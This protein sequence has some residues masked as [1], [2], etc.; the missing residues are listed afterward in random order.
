[1]SDL[2][3]AVLLDLDG[4]C[5]DSEPIWEHVERTYV[6]AHGA[7]LTAEHRRRV[8]GA[9]MWLTTQVIGEATGVPQDPAVLEPLLVAGVAARY[10][11][12]GVPW[13]PGVARLIRWMHD[14]GVPVALVTASNREVVDV[15]L[16]DAPGGGFDAVVSGSDRV[17]PKPAPDPY[18]L[19][20]ERAKADI[21]QCLVIE[22]S[23]TG[24]EGAMASGARVLGIPRFVDIA[25]RPGLNRLRDI[26]DLD[27]PTLARMMRGEGVD[28]FDG[29]MGLAP[30]AVRD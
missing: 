16:A 20:A 25:P 26:R 13:I 10:R 18:L 3:A 22:D 6:E 14:E 17:S 2:P 27:A 29:E 8:I 15:V 7:V 5:V 19:G 11:E 9:P 30:F 21:S 12:V 28:A 4:T 24:I 1:M 23:E